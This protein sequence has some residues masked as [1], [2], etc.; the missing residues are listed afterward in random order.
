MRNFL[1]IAEGVDTT[2][3]LHGLAQHPDLWDE[4]TARTT[5]PNT[6]H[7]EV[8]DI[9]VWYNDLD[10]EPQT[11]ANDIEV[12]PYRAWDELPQLR[13]VVFDLMRRVEGVRLGRVVI[14]RLP[15]GKCISL[16]TDDGLP[17]ELFSRYHLTLQ[18]Q[19]GCL[20][21]CWGETLMERTG[22]AFMFNNRL[23]HGVINN[24]ADDRLTLICDIIN[25]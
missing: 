15:P 19:A 3:I 22:T 20:F 2:P 14:T 11:I 21:K 18:A 12:R 5:Y 1:K 17:A 4:H 16:H 25:G 23:Q 10:Q 6:P 7:A 24:S 8:S 9:L 13:P